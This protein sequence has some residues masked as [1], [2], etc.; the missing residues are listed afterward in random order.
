MQAF[1]ATITRAGKFKWEL[2]VAASRAGRRWTPERQEEEHQA[3]AGFD[4]PFGPFRIEEQPMQP[5]I[6]ALPVAGVP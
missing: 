2:D 1:F 6:S 3:Q 5:M 4:D